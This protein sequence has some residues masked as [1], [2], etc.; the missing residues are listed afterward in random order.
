M[1]PLLRITEGTPATIDLVNQQL[2]LMAN[3]NVVNTSTGQNGKELD[4]LR[5]VTV[6]IR[7]SGPLMQPSYQV[8]WKEISSK[9]VKQ[10]VQE[11]L[12]DILS[13]KLGVPAGSAPSGSGPSTTTAP[14]KSPA[15][16]VKS[17]G[18]A[19]KGLLR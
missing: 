8:Q 17:L 13:N 18:D 2:D 14:P 11:G 7:I 4:A 10:A 12:V 19:L 6:P 9:A 5:G 15:D 1:A 16:P 3:V